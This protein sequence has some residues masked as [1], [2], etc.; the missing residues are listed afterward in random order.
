MSCLSRIISK[1]L[2]VVRKYWEMGLANRPTY[3][4]R[5]VSGLVS[6]PEPS[7]AICQREETCCRPHRLLFPISSKGSFICIIPHECTYVYM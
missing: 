3:I 4:N 1:F 5:P 6:V 7:L 2:L